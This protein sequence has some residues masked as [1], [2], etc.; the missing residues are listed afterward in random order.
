M[1]QIYVST[2]ESEVVEDTLKIASIRQALPLVKRG[3]HFNSGFSG[4]LCAAAREAL[5]TADDREFE[6]GRLG[7]TKEARAFNHAV[8]AEARSQ[9]ARLL[10]A[11]LDE[12]AL[13]NH[14][15]DGINMIVHGLPWRA[16]DNV[17]TTQIEHKAALLP[18]GVLRERHAVE[19]RAIACDP[20]ADIAVLAESLLQSIDERTRLLVLSH[21]SYATGAVLPVAEIVKAAHQRGVLVLV[22]GAQAAGTIEVDVKALGVDA[23]T[24][25]GQKWLCGPEGTAA[26]YV[27]RAALERFSLTF[28]GWASVETWDLEGHF[29]P[30]PNA[31][32]FEIGTRYIPA[33]AGFAASLCWLQDEVKMDWTF[34]RI[35]R[36]TRLAS[37][38]LQTRVGAQILTPTQHAGLI[39]FRVAL[40]AEKVVQALA[41]RNIHVRAIV[42][43]NCVRLSIG[44][45]HTEGEICDLIDA[46]AEIVA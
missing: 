39:S 44:F 24:V 43:Y 16:G 36:L 22:D 19:V 10:H 38:E 34:A 14:S 33:V 7:S 37:H 1:Q 2:P 3:G 9:V 40:P 4:P 27:S 20:L 28:V 35:Q 45:F 30:N 25:S 18:L 23:Y 21:V 29:V 26:L 6:M 46:I 17:V 31:T 41:E 13:T 32:R 8:L 12:I 15:T 5:R 42:G 11:D